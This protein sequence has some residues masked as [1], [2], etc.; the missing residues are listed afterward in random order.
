MKSAI[1]ISRVRRVMLPF[2]A[3]VC[4]DVLASAKLRFGWALEPLVATFAFL[5]FMRCFRLGEGRSASIFKRPFHFTRRGFGALIVYWL[6]VSLWV[7]VVPTVKGAADGCP[8]DAHSFAHLMAEVASGIVAYDFLFFWIH[9]L[10]HT[11]KTVSWLTAHEQHHRYAHEESA[12]RTVN[13]S[14]VDGA[15]QVWLL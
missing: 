15:L 5:A 13:H 3:I 4:T 12:H 2:P 6:G 8:S 7:S 9:L 1:K 14:V 11:N 10:M